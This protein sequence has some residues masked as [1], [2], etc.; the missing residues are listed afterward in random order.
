MQIGILAA[1]HL[2]EDRDPKEGVKGKPEGAKGVC[3][4]IEKMIA[5]SIFTQ[6]L[7]LRLR[8]SGLGVR[9]YLSTQLHKLY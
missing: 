5:P 1:T 2:T 7:D 3:N 6:I 4:N 8:L 9:E